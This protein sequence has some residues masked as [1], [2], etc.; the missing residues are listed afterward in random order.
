MP[1]RILGSYG[2]IVLRDD[3]RKIRWDCH[4]VF[5]TDPGVVID[6]GR[7]FNV[8]DPAPYLQYLA[9]LLSSSLD[10]W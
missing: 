7:I 6:G 3:S 9:H 2:G 10:S 1:G 5:G 8:R 4:S